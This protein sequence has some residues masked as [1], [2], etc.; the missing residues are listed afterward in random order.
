MQVSTTH[1]NDMD[2][3]IEDSEVLQLLHK[4]VMESAASEGHSLRSNVQCNSYD[5]EGMDNTS[6]M[7]DVACGAS[8]EVVSTNASKF[9]FLLTRIK[10]YKEKLKHIAKDENTDKDIQG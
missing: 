5:I 9:H 7:V 8:F 4:D 3:D 2:E 6:H 10:L 1:Y